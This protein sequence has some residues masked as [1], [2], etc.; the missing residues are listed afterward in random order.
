MFS[1][2]LLYCTT[3]R[4]FLLARLTFSLLR[5]SWFS[6]TTFMKLLFLLLLGLTWQLSRVQYRNVLKYGMEKYKQGPEH[7]LSHLT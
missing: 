3:I 2:L 4:I 6:P 1:L 5:F 7:F